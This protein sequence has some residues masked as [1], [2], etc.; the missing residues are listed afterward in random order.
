[1]Q[2]SRLTAIKYMGK[3][4]GRPQVLYRCI[5]G[6]EKIIERDRVI[7]LVTLSCGCLQL[8]WCQTLRDINVTHGDSGSSEYKAWQSMKTR[9]Y[10]ATYASTHRYKGRGL[11]VC[12]DWLQSYELFLRDM[13]RKPSE[14]HSLDRKDNSKGYSKDNCRWA[15][16][17]EQASNRYY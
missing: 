16:V 3:K 13:G 2:E 4:K 12:P 6:K 14:S 7:K 9:C 1:M 5:C 10:T 11:T 15:T 8:E 17:E